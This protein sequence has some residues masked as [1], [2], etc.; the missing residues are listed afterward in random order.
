MKSLRCLFVSLLALSGLALLP[1]AAGANLI[2]VTTTTDQFAGL[3]G[4]GCSLRDAFNGAVYGGSLGDCELSGADDTIK[5]PT[6]SYALT[7]GPSGDGTPNSGDLDFAGSDSVT[8]EP[9][10]PNDKVVINGGFVDRVFDHLGAGVGDLILRNITVT[11]GYPGVGAGF[12]GGAIRTLNGLVRAEGVTFFGNSSGENGGAIAVGNG[13]SFEAV[14]STFTENSAPDSGGGIWTANLGASVDLRN[15]T[16]SANTADSDADGIGNGGGLSGGIGNSTVNMTNSILA[17]N[18]DSSPM[19]A[20]QVPDCVS[21]ANFFPRFVVSTQQFGA[22]EC[23]V[24]LP[25]PDTNQAPVADAGLQSFADNGGPTPTVALNANSPAVMAGG[26]AF[27]DICLA[28]DQRGAVRPAGRCDIGAYQR[29]TPLPGVAGPVGSIAAFDGTSLYIRLKCP[30]RFKPKCRSSA[31]AVTS[32]S[33]GRAMTTPKAVVTRSGRY[34]VLRLTVRPGFRTRV[35]AMT[36][37]DR[38]QLV[39]RQKIRSKRIGNRLA[40]RRPATVIS[41]YK[42]RVRT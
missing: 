22:G 23:L 19:P 14:N 13:A 28:T 30:A 9:E 41:T 3:P 25:T 37:V 12:D 35:S 42:V 36:F 32:R 29:T 7:I 2:T 20:D 34:K 38:R 40:P 11:G 8:I 15:V 16:I 27:P 21:N 17:E 6:G 24:T 4:T 5:L 10:G 1:G 33:G 31:V 18:I 26:S 39:I